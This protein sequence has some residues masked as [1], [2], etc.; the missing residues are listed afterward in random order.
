MIYYIHLCQL[1]KSLD[2]PPRPVTLEQ[3]L[4]LPIPSKLIP[5]P[6]AWGA[7]LG[8]EMIEG[9]TPAGVR[10]RR[11][12]SDGTPNI[13]VLGVLLG[14]LGITVSPGWPEVNDGAGALVQSISPSCRVKDNLQ[15][16][17]CI[18]TL[19]G[20][21]A[22]TLDNLRGVSDTMWQFGVLPVRKEP[23]VVAGEGAVAKNQAAKEWE[24]LWALLNLKN[25]YTEIDPSDT[26]KRMKDETERFENGGNDCVEK[27][28]EKKKQKQKDQVKIKIRERQ[29]RTV[30][31]N[32]I[33]MKKYER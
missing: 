23:L 32:H 17:E 24:V 28:S 4:I 25:K 10:L 14:S 2:R 9:L 22:T 8:T 19:N 13:F 21:K 29:Q 6:I 3:R 16:G 26:A 12:N 27:K 1:Y 33:R 30:G 11:Y 20:K 5:I 18:V 31:T 7:T 15:V